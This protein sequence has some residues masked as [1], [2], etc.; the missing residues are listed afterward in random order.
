MSIAEIRPRRRP[1]DDGRHWP[2]E[3]RRRG[4]H[5]SYCGLQ[6]ELGEG[7]RRRGW[8]R[9][10]PPGGATRL[11]WRSCGQKDGHKCRLRDPNSSPDQL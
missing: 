2:R 4:D 3:L 11:R 5:A 6:S 10:M 7:G 9:R 8:F 1:Q